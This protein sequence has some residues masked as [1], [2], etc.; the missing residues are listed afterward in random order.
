MNYIIVCLTKF[1]QIC[2]GINR[3]IFVYKWGLLAIFNKWN[4]LLLTA[5]LAWLVLNYLMPQYN[6]FFLKKLPRFLQMSL[7][8]VWVRKLWCQSCSYSTSSFLRF[9][10]IPTALPTIWDKLWWWVTVFS[11]TRCKPLRY[12]H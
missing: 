2:L 6:Y 8:L 5:N 10:N 11:S 12:E 3:F 7:L 4:L 1:L 9:P